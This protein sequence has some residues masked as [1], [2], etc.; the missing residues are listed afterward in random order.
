MS[1]HDDLFELIRSLTPSEKRYF[2][3]H[4]DRYSNGGYKKQYEKLF[5]A[6]NS[7]PDEP[8][9]EKEFKRRNKGKAF[10]KNLP[11]DKNYLRELVLKVIRQY[12]SDSDP[13]AELPELLLSIRLLISKGL[14]HQVNKLIEKAM[15]IGEENEQYNE[16]LVI[17]DLLL[18]FYRMSPAEAPY[19]AKEI[20]Q[21]DKDILDKIMLTRQALYLRTH[22]AEINARAQWKSR[23]QEAKDIMDRATE[24]AKIPNLPKRAELSLL[25]VRQFYLMHNHEYKASLDITSE[26]L[27]KIEKAKRA[28]DYSPDQYRV[29]LSNYMNCALRN[30]NLDLLPPAIEKIK[31]I[32]TSSEKDMAENFR[33]SA[34]YELTYLINKK[35]FGN[36]DKMIDSIQAGLKKYKRFITEPQ[37]VTFI[38]NISLYSFLQKQYEGTLNYLNELYIIC[39]RNESY[40]YS[41]TIVRTMEWMCHYSIGNY[42]ILDASLRNLKRY[43]TDRELKNDF[44]D[45]M[46]S[47]FNQKLKEAGTK[48]A[49]MYSLK[50]RISDTNPPH[51]WEQLKELVL[52]WI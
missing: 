40:S 52:V 25:N 27:E 16:M 33:V 48:P 4:A 41:T 7:W 2:K 38:F 13:E 15:R 3:L 37:M 49:S 44:F 31:A 28:F 14:R 29:T 51:E 46:F 32:K 1:Q 19:T 45:A 11:S 17:N 35:H 47:A 26:W 43:F 12:G 22:I 5:D 42:E 39:G 20:E 10:L 18:K 21:M 34:T 36:A 24:L 6:L 8:Y 23:A 9:D 50:E 30:D